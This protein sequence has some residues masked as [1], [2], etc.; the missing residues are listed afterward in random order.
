MATT[1]AR[2][3]ASSRILD[4]VVIALTLMIAAL[5]FRQG[6]PFEP[7]PVSLGVVLLCC[8]AIGWRRRYPELVLG[9][10][11]LALVVAAQPAPLMLAAGTVTEVYGSRPRTWVVLAVASV[12]AVL[13]IAESTRLLGTALIWSGLVALPATVGLYLNSRQQAVQAAA[14]RAEQLAEE[15]RQ[16]ERTRI[17]REMHDVVA[18]QVSLI[19]LHAGAL[20]LTLEGQDAA[21]SARAIGRT[22][23]QAL[24]ELRNVVSLLRTGEDAAAERA[25]QASVDQLGALLEEWRAAGAHVTLTDR[26]PAAFLDAC[27]PPVGRTAY[28]VVREALTNVSKHA[29]GSSAEVELAE[30]DGSLSV[31]VRNSAGTAAPSSRAASGSGTGLYGLRERVELL[32]GTFEAGPDGHG[33]FRVSALLPAYGR[34]L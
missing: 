32:G 6:E 24:E 13:E 15:A 18:H 16:E 5:A 21:A 26:T 34:E 10:A 23:R 20:E 11:V 27:P 14:A 2:F 22:A 33:G 31:V 17:A 29:P 30:V 8:L 3:V 12:P 4:V 7:S 28:R 25:P 9:I 1:W 19:A